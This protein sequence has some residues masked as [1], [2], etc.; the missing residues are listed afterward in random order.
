MGLLVIF[1]TSAATSALR[2]MTCVAPRGLRKS[3]FFREAVVMIGLNPEN[4]ANWIATSDN[5]MSI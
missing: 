2:S 4:L 5:Q 3:A 1:V